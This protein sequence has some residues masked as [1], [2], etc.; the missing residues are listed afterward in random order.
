MSLNRRLATLERY[1]GPEVVRIQVW[2]GDELD[3]VI[4]VDP[5][6]RRVIEVEHP[7]RAA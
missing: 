7:G 2:H 3:R 4:V 1:E 6:A 5:A